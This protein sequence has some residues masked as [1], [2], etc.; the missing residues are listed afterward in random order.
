MKKTLIPF[1]V[2]LLLSSSGFSQQWKLAPLEL[3][4]GIPTFQYFGDI[5]GS[6]TESNLLGL[7]DISL[8][9]LRPGIT[10]GARYQIIKPLLI[11]GSYS[12][13]LLAQSDINSINEA[14]NY[15]FSAMINEVA[16]AAEFY[17][18]PE[19]DENYFYS[20]MQVRGGLRHYRQPLSLYVTL[21]AG[22]VHYK[23]T[24]KDALI[25]SSRFDN[26]KSLTIVVPVGI[27]IKYAVMPKISLGAELLARYTMTDYL[28]GVTT[29]FSEFNDI[30]Y[31]LNLTV[32]YKIQKRVKRNIGL[33]K[34]RFFFF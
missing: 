24:A 10:L 21:G 18:I 29:N 12:F 16:F 9:K 34:K 1:I 30:Y 4:G 6:A 19:S 8:S 26:S 32:N 13:G 23:V 20:I 2:F 15:A 11:K 22:G 7:K 27:G 33:P 14:R 31:S 17:L 25:N 28:D 3:F 5:G